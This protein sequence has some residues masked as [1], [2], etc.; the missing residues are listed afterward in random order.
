MTK[1]IKIPMLTKASQEVNFFT[2]QKRKAQA[3]FYYHVVRV[4]GW[5]SHKDGLD[6]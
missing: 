6:I 2:R 5:T 3:W 1:T 4:F